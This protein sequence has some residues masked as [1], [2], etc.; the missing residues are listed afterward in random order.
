MMLHYMQPVNRFQVLY[1]YDRKLR[2]QF[3]LPLMFTFGNSLLPPQIIDVYY[4]EVKNI[5]P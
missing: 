1:V 3:K 5:G 4:K 2:A